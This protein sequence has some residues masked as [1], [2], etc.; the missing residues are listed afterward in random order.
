MIEVKVETLVTMPSLS[1]S[2]SSSPASSDDIAATC[3]PHTFVSRQRVLDTSF[4]FLDTLA[5]VYDTR[6]RSRPIQLR[7]PLQF[8]MAFRYILLQFVTAFRHSL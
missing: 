7:M 5:R 4:S 8:V 3:G 6:Q 1:S 2:M